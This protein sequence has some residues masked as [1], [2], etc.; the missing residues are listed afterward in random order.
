MKEYKIRKN[1]RLQGYDYSS[2]GAYFITIC[3]KRKEKLLSHINLKK[4]QVVLT[5]YGIIVRAVLKKIEEKYKG[6]ELIAYVIMPTHVHLIINNC[7][8]DNVSKVNISRAIQKLKEQITKELGESIWQKS[9]HD[10]IIRNEQD[11]TEH[12]KYIEENPMRWQSDKYFLP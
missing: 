3:V 6:I 8:K 5:K 9:F 2:A 10:H 1:N 11:Y 4:S 12:L 7:E